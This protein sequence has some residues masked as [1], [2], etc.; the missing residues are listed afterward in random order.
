MKRLLRGSVVLA[1]AVGFLSC[2]GDPTDSFREPS[3]IVASPTVLFV[4][5]GETKQVVASLQDDQGSQIAGDFEIS[6]VGSGLTVTQDTAFQHTTAG[7]VI[8][9]QVRFNVTGTA[10][11]NSSFT[12]SAGGQSRVVPVRVTPATLPIG[13]SNLT[14]AWGDTITLTAPAGVLFTAESEVSFA[15]GPAGDIVSLS[16]DR[17]QLVVVPGPNTAGVVTITNTTVAFDE[18]L[19]FTITSSETVTSPTLTVVEATFSNQTPALGE[20]VTLTLPAGIKVIPEL[21]AAE[22]G[23]ALEGAVAPRDVVV[24]A[25]S[26][27][28][29]FVPAPNSDSV[30]TINGVVPAVLPQFPQLLQTTGKVTTPAVIGFAGTPTSVTPAGGEAVTLTLT[31][32]T[33]TFD[34]AAAVTIGGG[35]AFTSAVTATTISFIPVPGA[36]GQLAV[37]G[38][39]VAGFPLLLPADGVTITAGATVAAR[40]GSAATTT[41]PI[42]TAPA[43]EG[44]STLIYDAGSF[45]GVI[46]G[47]ADQ[48]YRLV[49]AT[50]GDYT[51]TTGWN[52]TADVDVAICAVSDCSDAAF[53]AAT[54]ANPEAGTLT[55]TPGTYF[56]VL[57]LFAGEAPPWVSIQVTHE[58]PAAP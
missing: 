31:T 56:L 37:D 1:V 13:I 35:P 30:V 43:A 28:I 16:P 47:P 19:I 23:F 58:V 24:A 5:V 22:G 9:N 32:P 42:I 11:A 14:P 33:F 29:S 8:P 17:T 38:V 48:A 21:V 44:A 15:A 49:V 57:N 27:S 53:F 46:F 10:V 12:L 50:A 45:P 41:G 3:G 4:N 25:D 40:P 39:L 6:A 7:L 54:A 26:G 51:V 20:T 34:P 18:T 2:S 52:N 36:A 55:L